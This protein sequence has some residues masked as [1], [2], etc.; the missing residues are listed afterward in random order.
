MTS[1]LIP[2]DNWPDMKQFTRTPGPAGTIRNLQ[3][4]LDHL[5]I[6]VKYNVISKDLEISD[7]NEVYGALDG[8][9]NAAVNAILSE[10]SRF[11]MP[12]ENVPGYLQ[13][14]GY[15]NQY[16]P[17]R[18]WV[19]SLPYDGA[20]NYIELLCETITARH[21]FSTEFKNLLIKKWL[22]SCIAMVCNDNADHW[23]KGVLT[24]QGRQDLGKTSWFWK[25]F[26]PDNQGWGK[27]GVVLKPDEKDSVTTAIRHWIIELGE[28]EATFKKSDIARIKAF[29]TN[30]K[31]VVR[32]P[33]DRKESIFPRRT[34]F[35]ASVNPSE[36]LHDSTGN[37]RFW[38]IPVIGI[39][40]HHDIDM[41][42]VWAQAYSMYQNGDIWHLTKEESEILEQNN[43]QCRELHPIEESIVSNMPW[44]PGEY[45]A[46]QILLKLGYSNPSKA[47][48][49]VCSSVLRKY[50]GEPVRK[51][52][53]RVF[54]I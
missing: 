12:R 19:D 27:E 1:D 41:Q 2:L 44:I 25:L 43:E 13:A 42:Q 28:L 16:N 20:L 46:T 38:V 49:N 26:P 14:I 7:P 5:Q 40:Y 9:K 51:S 6:Q 17:V 8:G 18:E 37:V 52:S 23:S 45:T 11:G 34:S 29:L 39:D 4:M 54:V 33:Y 22:L 35:F 3:Y 48:R 47:D 10:C 30:R 50:Y 31:D 21:D 24:F 32:M 15:K 36:F 53:G